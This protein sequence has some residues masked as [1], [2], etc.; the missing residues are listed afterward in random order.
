MHHRKTSSFAAD[1][2]SFWN[3]KRSLK[4]GHALH[5]AHREGELLNAP[6][7]MTKYYPPYF[8]CFAFGIKYF[9][10]Y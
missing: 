5:S 3:T 9:L 7:V 10:F 6:K 2:N 4:I 1:G 8:L